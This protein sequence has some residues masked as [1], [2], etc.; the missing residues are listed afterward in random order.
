MDHDALRNV[1][2]NANLVQKSATQARALAA[3]ARQESTAANAK[4]SEQVQQ[5]V[6]ARAAQVPMRQVLQT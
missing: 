1:L 6:N 5:E 4:A 3:E 2:S